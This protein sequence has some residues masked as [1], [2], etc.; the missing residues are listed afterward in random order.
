MVRVEVERA[1]KY[2]GRALWRKRT[3]YHR[4]NPEETKVRSVKLLGQGPMARDFDRQ[5]A[6]FQVWTAVLNRYT[7]LGIPVAEHV[8]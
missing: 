7:V 4:R 2:L 5:F 1:C 6:E 3:G 8:G